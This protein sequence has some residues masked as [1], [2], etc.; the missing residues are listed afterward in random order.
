MTYKKK[1]LKNGLR[2]ITV[3]IK[4]N[5]AVTM[6]VMVE[7]GSKYES[8]KIGGVSHFLEHMCFKGTEKRP[9]A[10]D[11]S[12]ELDS[13]GSQYN[14]FT[15]QEFT[16]YY[17]KSDPKH[18]NTIL[19]V[20]SDM[21]LNPIFDKNEIEKEK[22]VI[23]EEINMYEDMPQQDVQEVFMKLLYGDQ[24]AGWGIAG[25]KESVKA[26]TQEDFKD[27][28]NKHYVSGAT[29]VIVAG[30]FDEESIFEAIEKKFNGIHEGEKHSK[31]KVLESQEKP[32]I[33]IKN[34]KTDQTHIVIGTR[35]FDTF[36][37]FNWVLKV[38]G[39]ILGGG[40]SSRLFQ[41]LRDEMGVGYYVSAG[42]DTY[43]DH[44]C[45]QVSAGIDSSRIVETTKVILNEF[46]KLKNEDISEEELKKAKDYIIGNM[47][48]SLETSD[49]LA[50][51]YGYQ[52]ILKKNIQ[53]PQ[54]MADKVSMV[55]SKDIKEVA[56][57]IFQD[58]NLNMAILGNFEKTKE[59]EDI[60]H[61]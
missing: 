41:K 35:T 52:E 55:T 45:F 11:I 53:T 54:E 49:S 13:I 44:G 32:A 22:G 2:I 24:P 48:L 19:D 15:A 7:A 60:F 8:K 29:S 34:K 30:K 37:N 58:K 27:Y 43:T 57:M 26:L 12:R 3:P 21:Y 47:F 38:I 28:R 36:N 5:P 42:N 23:I 33:V 25:T 9:K 31:T 14:A 50:E 40:M 59:F 61:I 18:L 39:V 6:L 51:F 4:D 46:I 56:N 16:G 20:I 1:I 17:A 10:I